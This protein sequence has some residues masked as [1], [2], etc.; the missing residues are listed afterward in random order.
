MPSLPASGL[1]A[2]SGF[3]AL[4]FLAAQQLGLRLRFGLATLQLGLVNHGCG[5]RLNCGGLVALDEGALLA[6]LDLDR[7]RLAA[8]V[9]LLDFAGRFAGERDLLALAA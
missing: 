6:D 2:S 8:R 1:A 7:A 9:G 3:F 5:T 4:G